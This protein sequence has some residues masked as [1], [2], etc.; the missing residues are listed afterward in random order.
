MYNVIIINGNN[1]SGKVFA[2]AHKAINYFAEVGPKNEKVIFHCNM[3]NIVRVWVE[4]LKYAI[5]KRDD[6]EEWFSFVDDDDFFNVDFNVKH[7][8]ECRLYSDI[9]IYNIH[10]NTVQAE[11]HKQCR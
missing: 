6:E 11:W 10:Q 1:I 8:A 2:S 3:D 5:F 7:Y 9:V 4:T